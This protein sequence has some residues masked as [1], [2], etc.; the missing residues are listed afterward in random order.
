MSEQKKCQVCQ[1]TIKEEYFNGK[2]N[3]ENFIFCF[4][5]W[6]Q[7]KVEYE[8]IIWKEILPNTDLS[9]FSIDDVLPGRFYFN[10]C[11]VYSAENPNAP[12][13]WDNVVVQEGRV[14]WGCGECYIENHNSLSCDKIR[15][16]RKEY[17]RLR[18]WE[19]HPAFTEENKIRLEELEK[20][21]GDSQNNNKSSDKITNST[22]TER[23]REQ[24]QL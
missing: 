8:E 10:Y 19:N 18:S 21:Y 4:S 2:I 14:C 1:E 11:K 16:E 5:C 17:W 15:E 23:E 6:K 22:N 20:K 9:N 13:A 24:F 7:K 3:N 12:N